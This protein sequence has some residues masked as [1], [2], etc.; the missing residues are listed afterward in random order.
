MRPFRAANSLGKYGPALLIACALALPTAAAGSP[1]DSTTREFH[2][3]LPLAAG[4]TLSIEN[5]FGEIRIHGENSHEAAISATIRSQGGSQSQAEK[6]AES[7]KIEV[8]QDA[9]GITIRTVAPS[10]NPLVFRVGHKNSYSV[11]Y[12]I[13]VPSDA[14]LWVKNAFGNVEIRGVRAWKDVE[15]SHGQ[16]TVHDVGAS[17]LTNSFGAVEAEGVAG[18]LTV[19]NSNGAITVS[20]VKGILD[21][22]DRFGSITARNIQGS[23]TIAGGNGLVELTDA[24]NSKVNN[25][26]GRV[27]A[28]NIHGSLTVNDNNGAIEANTVSGSADLIGSFGAITFTNVTGHVKCTSNNGRVTGGPTGEDVYVRNSFGDVS[29]EQIGGGVE[30]ENSNG[31]ITLREIKGSATL[32]TSFGGIE[33]SGLRKGVRATTGNGRISLADVGGEV[34]AKTSFGAVS[35]QR[36][37]GNLTVENANGQVTASSVKGDTSARTSFAAVKLDDI[38]GHINVDNQNGAVM[39]TAARMSSGCSSISVKSSFSPIQVRLPENAGYTLTARTSFGRIN[40]ELP[41]TTVGQVG[42]DSLSGK[43]GNGACTLSLTN[44]NGNIEILKLAR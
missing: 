36:V 30:V 28:R 12:D 6:F 26:F 37:N 43:I 29:L 35:V 18:D 9:N 17:K 3:S 40:S 10:D 32:N 44:S 5:K 20:A 13:A 14:K 23:V 4:Q 2:K 24:G 1:Q 8:N 31:T 38:T 11:D 25:S 41:I 42:G 15:N 22:K 33:A 16:L 19:V 39:I 34:F 21:I 7:V 27:S